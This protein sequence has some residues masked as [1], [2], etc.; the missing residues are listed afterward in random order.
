MVSLI[1]PLTPSKVQTQIAEN[2]RL[3]RLQMNLT[4]E[5]LA[6]RAGVSLAT[7]RKFEQQGGISLTSF[8]KLQMVLDKL[9]DI[10]KA[11]EV[12]KTEFTSIDEVLQDSKPTIRKRGTRK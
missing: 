11:T 1:T 4:Q 12:K 2:L 6:K 8:L 10:L 5:G 3:H 7:L 9:A